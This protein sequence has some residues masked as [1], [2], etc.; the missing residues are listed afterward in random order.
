MT[1]PQVFIS[2]SHDSDEHKA[3]VA[4]LARFLVSNGIDV[5]IDAWNLR[6][7]EDIP[8]FME[9]GLSSADRVLMICTERYVEKADG[10]LG[11]VGYEKMIVTA[12]LMRF[13]DGEI[14]PRHSPNYAGAQDPEIHGRT[15]LHYQAQCQMTRRVAVEIQLL[16]PP[17][18]VRLQGLEKEG[19]RGGHAAV[20]AEQGIDRFAKLVHCPIQIANA[21][22]DRNRRLI[23]PP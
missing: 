13:G 1:T 9:D 8:K 5:I 18:V 4:D 11:G 23:H 14:R 22:A 2:Y 12:E 10:A 19:A 20:C 21:A 15:L 3:W 17:R 7:G 16:R 6:R